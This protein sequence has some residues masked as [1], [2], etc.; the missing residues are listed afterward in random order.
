MEASALC[1]Y[2]EHPNTKLLVSSV[3]AVVIFCN[4]QSKYS[5][6]EFHSLAQ[7]EVCTQTIRAF[8][9]KYSISATVPSNFK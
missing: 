4:S 8:Q 6:Y 7:W 2:V 3:C 5:E 9:G 1:L